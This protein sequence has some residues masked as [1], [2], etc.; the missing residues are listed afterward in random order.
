LN[1][2]IPQ[3]DIFFSAFNTFH[4]D[5]ENEGKP[6]VDKGVYVFSFKNKTWRKEGEIYASN[7][8][9]LEANKTKIYMFWTGK[10]FLTKFYD[11]PHTKIHLAD[12]IENQ[13]FTWTDHNKLFNHIN[14][15]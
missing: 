11:I 14:Y 13:I 10:Y 8:K 9:E 15:R 7:F 6:Q 1:G 3:K 5:S 4:N 2:F 12:P